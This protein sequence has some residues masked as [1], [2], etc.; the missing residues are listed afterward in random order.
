MKQYSGFATSLVLGAHRPTGEVV[1]VVE[2]TI[3]TAEVRYSF[4][5]VGKPLQEETNTEQVSMIF[6]EDDLRKFGTRLLELAEEA[7]AV[8][9]PPRLEEK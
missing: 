1:G 4:G 8:S 9:E 3:I 6:L 7:H 5:G 2:V